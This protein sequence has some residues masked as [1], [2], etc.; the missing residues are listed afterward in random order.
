MHPCLMTAAFVQLVCLR[1]GFGRP[2]AI[3]LEKLIPAGWNLPFVSSA[4]DC[5]ETP[6]LIPNPEVKPAVVTCS[7][8][9]LA[10]QGL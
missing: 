4:I 5:G 1:N 10:S 7:V 2:S 8:R 6:G 3:C 9:P